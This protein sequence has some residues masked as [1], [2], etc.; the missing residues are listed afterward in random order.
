MGINFLHGSKHVCGILEPRRCR[1]PRGLHDP[2]RRQEAASD[3]YVFDSSLC[4]FGEACVEP[5][6]HEEAETSVLEP[7]AADRAH[8][9]A[10]HAQAPDHSISLPGLSPASGNAEKGG[11]HDAKRLRDDLRA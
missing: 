8:E 1:G 11:S 9:A 10:A 5:A 4:G 7:T 3:G 2:L 6:E